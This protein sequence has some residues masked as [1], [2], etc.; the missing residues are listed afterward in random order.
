[1]QEDEAS[2]AEVLDVRERARLE[3]VDADRRGA[4]REQ[5][6]AEVRAEKPAPPVTTE[7]GIARDA[8]PEPG[9]QEPELTKSS[10]IP[11]C[12][13]RG[14]VCNDRGA[15]SEPWERRQP[16]RGAV[17][18][19]PSRRRLGA[20]PLALAAI[21][22]VLAAVQENEAKVTVCHQSSSESNPYQAISVPI[23]QVGRH[24]QR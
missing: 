16:T 19:P 22:A 10:R 17:A 4:P 12:L 14:V 2:L 21:P 20:P 18:A 24:D 9:R 5:R 23:V 11:R 8:T 7:V 3:V 1:M 6:L 13:G 15:S